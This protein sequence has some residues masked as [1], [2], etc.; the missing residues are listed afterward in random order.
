MYVRAQP[1]ALQDWPNEAKEILDLSMV[2]DTFLYSSDWPH[3]TLNP[4]TW[5]IYEFG[6]RR[7]SEKENPLHGPPQ[8]CRGSCGGPIRYLIHGSNCEC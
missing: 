1:M 4:A 3:Q 2:E 7:T 8:E 5:G 6:V